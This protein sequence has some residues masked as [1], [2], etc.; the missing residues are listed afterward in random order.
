MDFR[1]LDAQLPAIFPLLL[2]VV[3]FYFSDPEE[4]DLSEPLAGRKLDRQLPGIDQLERQR[5]LE[6]R[7]DEAG[8]SMNLK[9]QPSQRAPTL[10]APRN[11]PW[12]ANV[13][14]RRRESEVAWMQHKVLIPA[15]SLC[16]EVRSCLGL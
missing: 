13:L 9:T 12:Q 6:S 8:G 7:V 4:A 5:S 2:P 11:V 10:E 16:F 14:Q 3:H 1:K 15:N